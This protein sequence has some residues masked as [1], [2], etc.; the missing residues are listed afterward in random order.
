MGSCAEEARPR[1]VGECPLEAF[2]AAGLPEVG[3]EICQG[4]SGKND[5]GDYRA[6]AM[7][8]LVTA[9]L[10]PMG[11]NLFQTS[12]DQGEFLEESTRIGCRFLLLP[13]AV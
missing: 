3:A 1:L 9:G 6:Q 12:Q 7:E 4:S 13:V 8:R 10:G 5:S 2:W 11:S